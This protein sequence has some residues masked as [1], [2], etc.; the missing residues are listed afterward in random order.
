MIQLLNSYPDTDF[1]KC[2]FKVHTKKKRKKVTKNTSHTQIRLNQTTA[3]KSQNSNLPDD[4][5]LLLYFILFT[6]DQSLN[7]IKRTIVNVNGSTH[8]FTYYVWGTAVPQPSSIRA[9]VRALP[10]YPL[11]ETT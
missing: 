6:Q 11:H 5:I 1:N 8:R 10:D 2:N 9:R 3:R 7:T 4:I